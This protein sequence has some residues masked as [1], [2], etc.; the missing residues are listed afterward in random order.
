MQLCILQ[1]VELWKHEPKFSAYIILVK[2]KY[3]LIYREL[4]QCLLYNQLI[5]NNNIQVLLFENTSS[6]LN[7]YPANLQL[8]KPLSC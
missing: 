8:S 2:V 6:C 5:N 7:P 4:T 1:T 3:I